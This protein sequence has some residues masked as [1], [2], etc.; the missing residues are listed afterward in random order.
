MVTFDTEAD[1]VKVVEWLR[2][3]A[4]VETEASKVG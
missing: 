2:K 4:A 3:N 1:S